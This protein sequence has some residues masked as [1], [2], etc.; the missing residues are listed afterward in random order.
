MLHFVTDM[1]RK[2]GNCTTH[3]IDGYTTRKTYLG[4][5]HEIGK[6]VAKIDAGEGEI[7]TS[8]KTETEAK[9]ALLKNVGNDTY[10]FELEEVPCA[11]EYDEETDETKYEDG[12]FYFLIRFFVWEEEETTT[13]ATEEPEAEINTGKTFR[14]VT[15]ELYKITKVSDLT[16][17][18]VRM[19]GEY[20]GAASLFHKEEIEFYLDYWK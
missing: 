8:I 18:A 1:T 14:L 19:Y 17:W 20:E 6:M 2:E 5:V 9:Q 11:C 10:C 13:E 3:V 15:G 12:H 16:V 4:A 7:L